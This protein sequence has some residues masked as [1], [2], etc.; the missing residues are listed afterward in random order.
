MPER[1][2]PSC[3]VMGA[4]AAIGSKPSCPTWNRKRPGGRSATVNSP[5]GPLC[6]TPSAVPCVVTATP[7]IGVPSASR[8]VPESEAGRASR[9]VTVVTSPR[10]TATRRASNGMRPGASA[11]TVQ[12]PR[13]RSRKRAAPCASVKTGAGGGRNPSHHSASRSARTATCAPASGVRPSGPVSR[14]SMPPARSSGTTT[15]TLRCAAGN[16]HEPSTNSA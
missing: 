5:P 15:S 12:A 3:S 11:V 9:P 6:P 13:G 7:S 1:A 10:R 14:T 2:S 8:T 4:A 16:C